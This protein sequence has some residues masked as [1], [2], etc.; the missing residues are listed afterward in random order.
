M[1]GTT[2]RSQV[3]YPL[4]SV[5]AS[6]HICACIGMCSKETSTTINNV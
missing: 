3:A 6:N 5:V 2:G 4:P 1:S